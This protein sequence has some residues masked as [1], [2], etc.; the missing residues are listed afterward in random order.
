MTVL[1]V[2]EDGDD[3]WIKAASWGDIYCIKLKDMVDYSKYAYPFTTRFY[4]IY[5]KK[6]RKSNGS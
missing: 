2:I 5:E 1:A 3:I 4:K 6:G